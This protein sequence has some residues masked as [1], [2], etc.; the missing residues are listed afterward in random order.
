MKRKRSIKNKILL[1]Y[2]I[3]RP[4][5]HSKRLKYKMELDTWDTYI[6]AVAKP[7]LRIGF[8]VMQTILPC[9]Q[10]TT[11]AD[12]NNFHTDYFHP[13]HDHVHQCQGT[14]FEVL[15]S[16]VLACM[17][18]MN[19]SPEKEKFHIKSLNIF[20]CAWGGGGAFLLRPL[21]IEDSA[22]FAL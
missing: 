18:N 12:S 1:L 17:Q 6:F 7:L 19:P 3:T 11:S 8:D 9:N 2:F 22:L 15:Y 5:P 16:V 4:I 20:V 21:Y 10:H 14:A 13:K